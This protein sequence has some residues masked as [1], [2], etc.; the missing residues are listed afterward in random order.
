[1]LVAGV[2]QALRD[3]R[4]RSVWGGSVGGALLIA[5]GATYAA[6]YDHVPPALNKFWATFE[7]SP[8]NPRPAV[9]TVGIMA[10]GITHGLLG[11]PLV[12]GPFPDPFSALSSHQ[13]AEL[14]YLAVP[15][16]LVAVLTAGLVVR[17]LWTEVSA[18]STVGLASVVVLLGAV[19][20]AGT[21][22]APLGGG[23]TD[24]WWYPAAWCLLALVLVG[25]CSMLGPRLSH[26]AAARRRVAATA[27]CVVLSVLAVPFG[28]HFRAWYPAQDVRALYAADHG[29]LSHARWI[30]VE[31]PIAFAWAYYGLGTFRI[32][33]DHGDVHTD[34]GWSVNFDR[35][36]VERILVHDPSRLCRST[37]QIW[38]VGGNPEASNPNIYRFTGAAL[39]HV[40]TP[41]TTFSVLLGDGWRRTEAI[42]GNGVS[43]V[44][45]VHTGRCGRSP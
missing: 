44:L 13:Y 25:V 41:G 7:F 35:P 22:R 33:F 30:Y 12:V 28:V 14:T 32:V 5:I 15:V 11:T 24:M 18:A 40:G 26:V 39:R 29:T 2:V 36:D 9:H 3:P 20:A 37:N 19:F 6:F 17:R 16:V 31:R 43:A 45:F 21:G 27:S 42:V 8:S 34:Q 38:W 10:E 4:L 23:R 1:V